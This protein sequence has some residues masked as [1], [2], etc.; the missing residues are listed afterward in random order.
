VVLVSFQHPD[1]HLRLRV[2]RSLDSGDK[3]DHAPAGRTNDPAHGLASTRQRGAGLRWWGEEWHVS[4]GIPVLRLVVIQPPKW[5]YSE[6]RRAW[7][8][9]QARSGSG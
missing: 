6:R 8:Q 4:A 9:H 2:H 1:P 3:R 5:V 7:W